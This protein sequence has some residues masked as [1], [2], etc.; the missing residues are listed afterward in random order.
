MFPRPDGIILG[1][2]FEVDEW[3][4]VPE[5]ATISRIVSRQK[6]FFDSFRCT[7]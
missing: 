2:T 5:P 4:S 1:G 3:S 7:A 6:R